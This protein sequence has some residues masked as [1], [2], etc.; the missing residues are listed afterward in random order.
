MKYFVSAFLSF[1]LLTSPLFAQ[2]ERPETIIIPV[3]SLGNVSEV[4]KQ[5]L[6]NTLTDELK[7]HFRIVPQE[8]YEEALEQV[9]Q[10]LNYEECTEDS[11]II[12]IQ[13][14]LQ[15][16]D[17]FNLQVIGEGKNTQLN[18]TWRT[19]DEKSNEEDYCEGCGTRELRKMI[20]GLVEKLV[21]ERQKLIPAKQEKDSSTLKTPIPFGHTIS[22]HFDSVS[23]SLNELLPDLSLTK[24]FAISWG[25]LGFGYGLGTDHFVGFRYLKGSG[26]IDQFYFSS[27]SSVGLVDSLSV[28]VLGIYYTPS[29]R[30]GWIYG[31][32]MENW[33]LKLHSNLG[34]LNIRNN[35]PLIDGGYQFIVQELPLNV[36]FRWSTV[37]TVLN[38]DVS[39]R[40]R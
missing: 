10:E 17:V 5:I 32:G 29:N 26:N 1:L 38:F 23:T 20:G 24:K 8:K 15:V 14:M 37:G 39:W 33:Q 12:R 25:I 34:E 19:L 7:T 36:K 18:L 30:E 40:F 16:E 9:F 2:S 11:C 4:R 27:G 3:S 6:Q 28:Q 31:L 22:L 35:V 13:E 21:V